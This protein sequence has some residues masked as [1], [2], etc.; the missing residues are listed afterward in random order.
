MNASM[1][2]SV[3]SIAEYSE[4]AANSIIGGL[5]VVS[6][7]R[8]SVSADLA[9]NRLLASVDLS[10]IDNEAAATRSMPGCAT[11]SWM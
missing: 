10:I 11:A 7:H 1:V 9:S 3:V 6:S 8:R 4:R 5:S 2:V